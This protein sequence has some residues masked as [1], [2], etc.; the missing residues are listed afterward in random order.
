VN[1]APSVAI[2]FL[3]CLL[4]P[5]VATSQKVQPE[6]RFDVLGPS[7][8]LLQA[9][10]GLVYPFGYYV[11]SSVDVAWGQRHV[12]GVRRD[13][14]R[15]DFLT[16][17]TLDPFRQQRWGFSLGGGLSVRRHIYLAAIFDLEG[18]EVRGIVPAIQI[19]VGGGI[20]GGVVFRKAVRGRR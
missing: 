5:T 3:S 10:G 4:I 8:Y 1:F 12:A 7:P 17:V 16:R 13:E 11:R 2:L 18:P 15:A 19:G 20:R 14:W 6:A 9:G